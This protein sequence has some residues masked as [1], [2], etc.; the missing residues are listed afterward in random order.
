MILDF[1]METEPGFYW[2]DDKTTTI[3]TAIASCW[4]GQPKTMEC[5]ILSEDGVAASLDAFLKRYAQA[6]LVTGPQHH[7]L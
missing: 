6:D 4:V 2:F 1:D 7:P 5:H 3:I